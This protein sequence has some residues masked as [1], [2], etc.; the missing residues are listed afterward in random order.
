MRAAE[1]SVILF[2]LPP[3]TSHL[4]LLTFCSYLVNIAGS[5]EIFLVGLN[6]NKP[7]LRERSATTA[8]SSLLITASSSSLRIMSQEGTEV[9][10]TSVQALSGSHFR[11]LIKESLLEVLRKN[12]QVLRAATDDLLPT[13]PSEGDHSKLVTFAAFS[14]CRCR[15]WNQMGIL[16]QVLP[17][18]G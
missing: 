14:S 2:T 9:P 3:H 5:A 6:R 4:T 1:E 16:A 10:G 8:S 15:C 17:C 18:F 13:Q 12:P 11:S 7:Q